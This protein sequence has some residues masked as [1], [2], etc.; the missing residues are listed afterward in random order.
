MHE[1]Y[2]IK[3]MLEYTISDKR[4]SMGKFRKFWKFV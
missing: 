4:V 3:V 1:V 2:E